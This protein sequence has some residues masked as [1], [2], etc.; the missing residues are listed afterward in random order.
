MKK[1][2]IVILQWTLIFVLLVL[3]VFGCMMAVKRF[4]KT[5]E[6]PVPT[7]TPKTTPP[8]A[9]DTPLPTDTPAPTDTPVPT[10]TPAPTDTPLP[11][12]TPA[13]TDIP[14]PTKPPSSYSECSGD[15]GPG[16]PVAF[17]NYGLEV[18][19]D[20]INYF[21]GSLFTGDSLMM[22]FKQKFW[23]RYAN[24]GVTTAYSKAVNISEASF[25]VGRLV[26][27][28]LKDQLKYQ[29]QRHFLW[30]LV[31]ITDSSKVFLEIGANDMA[32]GVNAFVKNCEI[33]ADKILEAR[34]GTEIIFIN[35]PPMNHNRE[36]NTREKDGDFYV[37]NNANI[38]RA[39]AGLEKMCKR[40]GFGY[41]DLHAYIVDE[42]GH[43]SQEYNNGDSIHQ[44]NDGYLVWN[45]LLLKYALDHMKKD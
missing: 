35:I 14:G 41:I 23:D 31:K 20:F 21:K 16:H 30:D 9:T 1:N 6:N 26:N 24:K 34:P 18:N 40:R 42:T 12:D 27:G 10:D 29:D 33:L 32:G 8:L 36:G 15:V 38:R 28:A 37:L 43:L 22:H 25:S 5:G 11:T 13:P 3:L 7:D 45:Q 4:E 19:D 2:S 39:N 44:N 17:A